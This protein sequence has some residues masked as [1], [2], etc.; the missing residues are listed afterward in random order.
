MG[1]RVANVFC[2]CLA[3]CGAM[4]LRAHTKM[5]MSLTAML[6]SESSRSLM[7][8]ADQIMAVPEV[9]VNPHELLANVENHMDL[10]TARSLVSRKKLPSVV[11]TMVQQIQSA[12]GGA[13]VAKSF[14]EASLAKA[15]TALNK[16]YEEAWKNLDEAVAECKSFQEQFKENDG[17]VTRDISRLVEQINDL[18]RV[19]SDATLGIEKLKEDVQ[20]LKETKQT[21]RR[22][23]L[24]RDGEDKRMLAVH[25]GDLAVYTYVVTF[26]GTDCQG[27]TKASTTKLTQICTSKSGGRSLVFGDKDV[28]AGFENLLTDSSKKHIQDILAEVGAAGDESLLQLPTDAVATAAQQRKTITEFPKVPYQAVG[29]NDCGENCVSNCYVDS[30]CPIHDKL[31]L[32]WGKFKDD[33]D[34]LTMQMVRND[35]D[36]QELKS[37]LNLQVQQVTASRGKL[38][39]LLS[40]T[41]GNLA[42]ARQEII[43]KY[44]LKRDL[45]KQ[46][47]G[48]TEKMK[49]NICW[50]A[51]QDMCAVRVVRNSL[52]EKSTACPSSG[53]V[54]CEVGAWVP[55][56]C[57][58][59]CDDDC[60]TLRNPFECGG[61]KTMNREKVIDPSSA[62]PVDSPNCSQAQCGVKCPKLN[63]KRRCGQ[64]KCPVDCKLSA[65]SGY[66]S[67]SADCGGGVKKQTRSVLQ[68]AKNGGDQCDVTEEIQ[69]C[70][71][72]SC[73]RDCTLHKW[74]A[75][76]GC[77]VACGGGFQQRWRHVL[78]PTRGDGKC[79]APLN[80][81]RHGSRACNQQACIG[82]EI[83]IAKQDLVIAV[84][85]SSSIAFSQDV[86]DAAFVALK[87]FTKRLIAKYQ[88]SYFGEQT[89]QI[90]LITFG[91][92]EVLKKSGGTVAPAI[93]SHKLS[94]DLAGVSKA[95]CSDVDVCT[96]GLPYKKGFTNMA[97][98]FALAK[99]MFRLLP[100]RP[101]PQAVM[102]VTD[103][104][105]SFKF[106]TDEFV[107]Q[108]ED[109]GI[110]RYFVVVTENGINSNMME[111]VK[112]WA[113]R[114][115]ET[116]VVHIQGG[117]QVLSADPDIWADKALV[118]F[119]PQAYSPKVADWQSKTYG[120]L[121]VVQNGWCGRK[122]TWKKNRLGGWR[123]T[124]KDVKE[125]ALLAQEKNYTNFV[126][127]TYNRLWVIRTNICYGGALTGTTVKAWNGWK[128]SPKATSRCPKDDSSDYGDSTQMKE[129]YK[130]KKGYSF[131]AIEPPVVSIR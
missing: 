110:M 109:A 6:S 35:A 8:F 92:G 122:R 72:Q 112:S 59:T 30:M 86:T 103:G 9:D 68:G 33:V 25:K 100:A 108:L 5:N 120:Y 93:L 81:Q 106:Q 42:A 63:Q 12:N 116:N 76:T 51:S 50:I 75:Y 102:V 77:S 90:G 58:K 31:S 53:I 34:E 91:N 84:D 14:D 20:G 41:K 47:T 39:A 115:W 66:S 113:S 74:T 98:A 119:C 27:R 70:N 114:P 104:Q 127:Q 65:W 97:Q 21:E 121:L 45:T 56:S 130:N 124:V 94:N 79:A 23:Y 73:D 19:E 101:V 96:D 95:V 125:C 64:V 38:T 105:P 54:D 55:Q 4:N 61:W 80:A 43:N 78:I 67:C 107:N 32:L 37:N 118:K 123:A 111:S 48:R 24:Q 13:P 11:S 49:K 16:L 28:Q 40:E 83:C 99:T 128:A 22:I 71:S 17:Q 62:C 36:W 131:Y 88:K 87:Q 89:M 52:L 2:V 7:M 69:N 1:Q 57:D 126:Y 44:K 117:L 46:Y 60:D 18:S 15:R 85:A 10:H 29:S 3:L 129:P 82:D 26:T